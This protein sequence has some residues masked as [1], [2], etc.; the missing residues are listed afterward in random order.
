LLALWE[1][2]RAAAPAAARR[3]TGA[4]G[5]ACGLA[6]LT[7]GLIGVALVCLAFG[8]WAL[9]RRRGLGRALMIASAATLVGFIVAS[10]WYLAMERAHAGYLRYYFFQRHVL[11]YLTSTQSH[12]SAPWWY[13]GPILI[14]GGFPWLAYTPLA[15]RRRVRVEHDAAAQD[16]CWASLVTG[17]LFL[18]AADS[19]LLTYLLPVFPA[20]ASLAAVAWAQLSPDPRAGATRLWPISVGAHVVVGAL[21]LLASLLVAQLRFGIELSATVW[22]AALAIAGAHVALAFCWS[23]GRRP[24]ALAAGFGLVAATFVLLMTTVLPPVAERLSARA[25]AQHLNAEPLFGRLWVVNERIGSV[26][27][28]LDPAIRAGLTPDR[29]ESVDA[30][31]LGERLRDPA[32]DVLLAVTASELARFDRHGWFSDVPFQQAGAFRVYPARLVR[33]AMIAASGRASGRSARGM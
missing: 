28:Y 11:G 2:H 20:V 16:L 10:P 29:L 18:S 4:A 33:L 27:F 26:V 17:V 5:L 21:M 13:Y 12:G 32:P 23:A 24:L 19:K 30:A 7:K 3:W 31:A 9:W 6:V 1:A 25:L 8:G 22:T 15:L 14:G